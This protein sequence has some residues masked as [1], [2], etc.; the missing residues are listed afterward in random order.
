MKSWHISKPLLFIP[1]CMALF[2]A[3]C[4]GGGG[5]S[6]GGA[7]A[8]G[9]TTISGIA[10]KGP[11]HNATI[12]VY[13]LGDD[14]SRGAQVGTSAQTGADGS[15]SV[16]LGDVS[17]AVLV[18]ASGGTYID[19]ATGLTRS[20]ET[21]L[22]TALVNASG[23]TTAA[24]TALTEMAVKL[25]E[26][27]DGKLPPATI[28]YAQNQVQTHLANNIDIVKTLPADV[29]KAESASKSRH[30]QEYGVVLAGIANLANE[31]A[32]NV[33]A[34][35][36]TASTARL[37]SSKHSRDP[38]DEAIAD[39][40]DKIKKSKD[41]SGKDAL[42]AKKQKLRDGEH[43]FVKDKE[44]N[45]TKIEDE[46]DMEANTGGS[47]SDSH[48]HSHSHSDSDSD[49]GTGTGT[50]TGTSTG[51]AAGGYTLLAA[52]DLGIHCVDGKDY[53][54]FSILPPYN[55]LHA[56]LVNTNQN[57]LVTTGVTL[58]YEAVADSTGSINTSSAGKTNF[59]T[60][61]Q[62]LFGAQPADNIGLT[63][64]AA[65]SLTPQAMTFNATNGWFEATALPVVPYDDTMAK[66]YY[67]MVKVVAKDANGTILAT[68]RTV[69]PVSDEMT[70]Q[71]CHASTSGPAAKPTSGWVNDADLE[72]DWKKNILR[73]HDDKHLGNSLYT[74]ALAQ[75][76]YSAQGL[77]ATAAAGQP[78][79]CA[80]CHASNALETTGVAGIMS[81][82]SALHTRHAAAIDPVNGQTLDS[83]TNRASCYNCHPGS[84]TKCLRG[85]MGTAVDASGNMTMGCQ[86]CHGNMTAVGQPTRA[87]WLE[88]PN[89]QSCHHDGQRETNA[90]TASGM[91]R[92]P[93]DM[94]FATNA[95]TPA[96][97]ISLFRFSKGHG[98][99]QCE[100]CHG[101]THAEYPS[102]HV[103]DNVLSIDAQGHAGTINECS[104]CHATVPTTTNGGPHGMHTTGNA[105]VKGHKSAAKSGTQACAACHG[106]DFRGTGLSEVKMTKTFTVEKG[107]KTF[108]ARQK[109]G[110]YDC[111]N[112]PSGG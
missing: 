92:I 47:G 106:A 15:Y 54:I 86:S 34:D 49:S 99:L 32:S 66:N 8:T 94:R 30:E 112:G 102:S 82:T 1:V 44:K 95:N 36:S 27:P 10:S 53:S 16:S 48:S 24:V 107:T 28:S 89:C 42:N 21:P 46:N 57:K 65:P 77:A 18:E 60:W 68:A 90:L 81:L 88:E 67:P 26:T 14:G 50:G 108:T 109:V 35:A 104:A 39:L 11:L 56:Q 29:L 73:L 74:T 19:E 20:L 87:G 51:Q 80:N 12:K 91:L 71:G 23:K 97:G 64:N 33:S 31:N 6:G 38:V 17:G 84:E 43:K 37:L 5:G 58:T 101:A 75:F 2:L 52:N 110:C 62:K 100:S 69:L 7:T 98:G 9:A 61:A 22:R 13:R 59:W 105:W 96:A 70:C 72:K 103:N 25:A 45:K 3:G 63:G 85:A 83:S 55:N 4:G 79:L 78:I 111:H 93:T 76:N 40:A 41:V